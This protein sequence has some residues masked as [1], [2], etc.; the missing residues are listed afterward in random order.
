MKMKLAL[1]LLLTLL[2]LPIGGLQ[3]ANTPANAATGP[4]K[5]TFYACCF[6]FNGSVTTLSICVTSPNSYCFYENRYCNG[7][8]GFCSSEL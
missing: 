2:I 5:E 8:L 6:G 4:D 1:L 7:N 3:I